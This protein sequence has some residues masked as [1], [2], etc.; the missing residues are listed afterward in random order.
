MRFFFLFQVNFSGQ[1][2]IHRILKVQQLFVLFS[3]WKS[4]SM[5]RS[6]KLLQRSSNILNSPRMYYLQST[7][8]IHRL[9]TEKIHLTSPVKASDS[10]RSKVKAETSPWQKRDPS[11]GPSWSQTDLSSSPNIRKHLPL[12]ASTPLL[13]LL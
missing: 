2:I 8:H 9:Q 10:E 4:Y 12:W 6:Q 13:S 3:V 11:E 5:D 7:I 1:K